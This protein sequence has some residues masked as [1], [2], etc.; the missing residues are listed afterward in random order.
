LRH[1]GV[2]AQPVSPGLTTHG[3]LATKVNSRVL[4]IGASGG[5]GHLAIQIAKRGM[6]AAFVVGVC[7][8]KNEEFIRRC[9]ADDVV[10]YDRSL[11]ESIAGHRPQWH[12]SFDLIFDA[13]GLDKAWTVLAPRLLSKN[14]RFVGA[15]LQQ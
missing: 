5:V 14:G 2:R 11:I 8:S 10:A 15:A 3:G 6:G 12:G 4:V 13:M 1:Q 7:S 9:V